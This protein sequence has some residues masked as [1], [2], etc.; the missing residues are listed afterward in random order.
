[1]RSSVNRVPVSR[2]AA[3]RGGPLNVCGTWLMLLCREAKGDQPPEDPA[4]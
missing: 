2:V 3:C 1:V 4:V